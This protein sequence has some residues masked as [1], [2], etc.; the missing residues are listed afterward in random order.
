MKMS[1]K[2]GI[3]RSGDFTEMKY[4]EILFHIETY[5]GDLMVLALPELLEVVLR[6]EFLVLNYMQNTL[7]WSHFYVSSTRTGHFS[8]SVGASSMLRM[9]YCG[10]FRNRW[11]PKATVIF[12]LMI[13]LARGGGRQG[14][15]CWC[16]TKSSDGTYAKVVSEQL[17]RLHRQ[18]QGWD[19]SPPTT[20]T[21]LV[22]VF[23]YSL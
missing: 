23:V 5:L 7:L 4:V 21:L 13:S 18:V 20:N 2:A 17:P 19:F 22:H 9:I 16:N 3:K 12:Y 6:L 15:P 8:F 11:L 14:Q 10:F 1:T